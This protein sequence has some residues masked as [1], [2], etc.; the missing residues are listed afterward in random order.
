VDGRPAGAGRACV[1]AWLV[2][3]VVPFSIGGAQAP[4]EIDRL[5]SQLLAH[6]VEQASI[7]AEWRR[8]SEETEQTAREIANLDRQANLG[9]ADRARYSRLRRVLEERR[10]LLEFLERRRV[11]VRESY[12][13]DAAR[14]VEL[15]RPEI[16]RVREAYL[17]ASIDSEARARL[18]RE[19]QTLVAERRALQT[20]LVPQA[21]FLRLE[22]E[23][24]ADD[25]PDSLAM[26]A[27]EIA[28]NRDLIVRLLGAAARWKS[29]LMEDR[30]IL[31]EV[32]RLQAENEFFRIPDP[33]TPTQQ[34][35]GVLPR[36]V[37]IPEP[38]ADL[39]PRFEGMPSELTRV[40]DFDRLIQRIEV[41]E[42][43]FQDDIVEMTAKERRFRAEAERREAME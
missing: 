36:P 25:T 31:L 12:A 19:Y 18:F 9:P 4:G 33:L 28:D 27:D 41:L 17:A 24:D 2:L 7:D 20:T 40:E 8:L 35:P 34:P 30:E 15:L 23:M 11:L 42:E 22:I 13:R 3:A 38:L 37:V 5:R 1:A 14:L 29:E 39:I 21:A 6:E 43:E 16:Q 26:K 10:E 32:R